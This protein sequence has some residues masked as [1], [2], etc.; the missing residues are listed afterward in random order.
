MP[1]IQMKFLKSP[2]LPA[3]SVLF[4]LIV[5][6]F[7]VSYYPGKLNAG[8]YTFKKN[9]LKPY[10]SKL[11]V[12]KF[13]PKKEI[14]KDS[15]PKDNLVAEQKKPKLD[16][17]SH[18]ILLIGDSMLEGLSIRFIDYCEANNHEL[19][20]LI[21]YSSNTGWWGKSDT[22]THYINKVKP[23]YIIFAI[24]SGDISVQN[25]HEK[26]KPYVEEILNKIKGIPYT[27]V[28]PPNWKEDTGINDLLSETVEEGTFFLSKNLNF[29]R[30]SDGVHPTTASAGQWMDSIATFIMNDSKYR[31]KLDVPDKKTKKYPTYF[32]MAPKPPAE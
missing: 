7:L 18:R 13:A 27:W 12:D 20:S 8:F 1:K 26:R 25:V 28:G 6:L 19:F 9:G 10:F 14:K 24:G 17:S 4:F 29:E 2:Y 31:I 16:T 11:N 32:L 15:L 21:W 30:T 22:M 5:Y 23:T 3:L